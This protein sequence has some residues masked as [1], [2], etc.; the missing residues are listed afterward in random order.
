MDSHVPSCKQACVSPC[1]AHHRTKVLWWCSCGVL[2]LG[3][4]NIVGVP[5]I[6]GLFFTKLLLGVPAVTCAICSFCEHILSWLTSH[7]LSISH[8]TSSLLWCMSLPHPSD[9]FWYVDGGS[10]YPLPFP[11]LPQIPWPKCLCKEKISDAQWHST[12][13]RST[14]TGL[15]REALNLLIRDRWFHIPLNPAEQ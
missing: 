3:H 10:I 2:C 8:L 5:Q 7:F 6:W 13:L 4:W 11:H 9:Q 1:C 14:S 15:R 12:G